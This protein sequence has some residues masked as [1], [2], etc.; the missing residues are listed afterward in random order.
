MCRG[1]KWQSR[2]WPK[3]KGLR[4]INQCAAACLKKEGCRAFDMSPPDSRRSDSAA[5]EKLWCNLYSNKGVKPASGVPGNC[6]KVQKDESE[7]MNIPED[8][9]MV[10]DDDVISVDEVDDSI[11]SSI[12]M[13]GE[14]FRIL[15]RGLCRG[16]N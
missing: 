12:P 6:Y 13:E 5:S 7:L 1:P 3:S 14:G 11:L 15:G 4:T 8:E 16:P 10:I 2:K 9:E